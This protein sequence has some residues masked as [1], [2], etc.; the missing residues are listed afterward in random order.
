MHEL[1]VCNCEIV[2]FQAFAVVKR[3]GLPVLTE[4]YFFK[5]KCCHQNIRIFSCN[6]F[7]LCFFISCY[8]LFN[9]VILVFLLHFIA[10]VFLWGVFE[11]LTFVTS[12]LFWIL[13]LQIELFPEHMCIQ[14]VVFNVA[15][16]F[17]APFKIHGERRS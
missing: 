9:E 2:Q 8:V 15:V 3:N 16:I 6:Q 5:I 12:V 11:G 10:S 17:I 13:K 1:F 4:E 14:V 7:E